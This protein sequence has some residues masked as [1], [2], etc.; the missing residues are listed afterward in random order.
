LI[1]GRVI[2]SQHNERYLIEG[3]WAWRKH[4]K[5]DNFCYNVVMKTM[6]LL[7]E[8]HHYKISDEARKEVAETVL[9]QVDSLIES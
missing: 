1:S 6:E 9:S 5:L 2:L 3:K 7:E 8:Q 4:V